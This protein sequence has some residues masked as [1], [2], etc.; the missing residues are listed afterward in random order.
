MAEGWSMNIKELARRYGMAIKEVQRQLVFSIY[1]NVCKRTPVDTG[2]ARGN[3]NISVN[4]LDGDYD[5]N[6]TEQQYTSPSQLPAAENNDDTFYIYNNL[7][8]ITKLEY[9]GYTD[10]PE[11]EKT[12]NGFSKQAPQGMVGVTLANIERF[13]EEAVRSAR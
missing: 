7:P 10:K 9:G 12:V 13:V 11:T 2:R 3:W 1:N 6:R 8:Y 5:E 4:K